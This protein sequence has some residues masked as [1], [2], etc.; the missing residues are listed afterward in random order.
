MSA[1]LDVESLAT[2]ALASP[3]P[4]RLETRPGPLA[5]SNSANAPKMWK[6]SRPLPESVSIA[7]L[8]LFSP[9][10][11]MRNAS[12]RAIRSLPFV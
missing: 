4:R 6:M 5:R 2:P 12:A 3:R 8:R 1:L 7:S 9:T 11:W 10:P